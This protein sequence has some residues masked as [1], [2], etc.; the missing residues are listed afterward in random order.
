MYSVFLKE[1]EDDD[2]E[3][4]LIVWSWWSGYEG[5]SGDEFIK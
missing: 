5:S 4:L 1:D 2:E 3:L